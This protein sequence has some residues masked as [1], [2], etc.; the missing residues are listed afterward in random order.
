MATTPMPALR[1]IIGNKNYSSW[2]LRPWLAMRQAGIDF[3]ETVVQL[4][5]PG[6]TDLFDHSPAGKVP[7]LM[8]GDTR[9]WD[10]IAILEY[11]AEQ[12]P[13]KGLWPD[14][15]TA[16]AHARAI[17]AEMHS[18]F[19]ALRAT[20]PMNVRRPRGKVPYDQGVRRDIVRIEQIWREARANYANGGGPFLFGNFT[21][22]DAMF[23]PVVTRFDTYE[24]DVMP[25]SR[26]YMDAV[27]ALR[28]F[29]DWKRA[30]EAESWVIEEEE[31]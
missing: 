13:D 12:Y 10:S 22:A 23:A 14:D 21:I 28:A 6:E 26:A 24:V 9:I 27:L 5:A 17:S 15:V 30:A 25:E 16:R 1:L 7:V 3:E 4:Y 31:I 19:V 2:S 18:S 11:L 29:A 8:S 20:L